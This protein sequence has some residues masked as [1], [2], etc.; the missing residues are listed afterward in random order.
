MTSAG[1]NGRLRLC[2]CIVTANVPSAK[3][4]YRVGGA[5]TSHY[6][7]VGTGKGE[8]LEVE[9]NEP[10]AMNLFETSSVFYPALLRSWFLLLLTKELSR[11]QSW[12]VDGFARSQCQAVANRQ[13]TGRLERPAGLQGRGCLTSARAAPRRGAAGAE[14]LAE[15]AGGGRECPQLFEAS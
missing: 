9:L 1:T 12:M 4:S 8:E 7:E 11:A 15:A 10:N 13:G 5:T 14:E 3:A 6:K 2:P